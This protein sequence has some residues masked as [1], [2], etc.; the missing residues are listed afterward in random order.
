[1]KIK[2]TLL[3]L[4]CLLMV[5]SMAACSPSSDQSETPAS[6]AETA[7]N[8]GLSDGTYTASSKGH[9]GDVNVTV[10]ISNGKVE[11]VQIGEH[12]ETEGIYETP[13]ER[14]PKAIVEHQ[15]IAIDAVSG[16]TYT[17][18]AILDAVSQCIQQAGGKIEDFSTPVEKSSNAVEEYEADVVVI[19]AGGSGSASAVAAHQKGAKVIVIEKSANVGGSAALSGGMAAVNSSLQIADPETTFTPSEWLADWL[20]QQNYMVSAP[21]IYKF[22]SESGRT[23]DWLLENGMEMDFVAH[24][25]EALVDSPFRTYHAWAGEGFAASMAK[26][27]SKLSENN[28]QLMTETTATQLIM[29]DGKIA[30]VRA[31]K[32]DG[33]LVIIKSPAVILATGGYGASEEQ[34]M[35]VLGFKTNGIN[36]GTQTGD[37]IS[38]AIAVGAATEG[39]SN[40]EFHGAHSA[41]DL[42][43]DLPN[44]G[45]SLNHMAI[46]AAGL[47]VNVDGYRFTN[48]D[49]CYDSSYIGNVVAK[50]G[51]HY[52]VLVDQNFIDTLSDTG[53][54]GLGITK[55]GASFGV[56]GA[57]HDVAW[58]TLKEEIEAGLENGVTVKADTLEDLAIQAGINVNNLI[59]T[60]KTY[61]E[62]CRAGT[63]HMFSKEEQF[64]VPVVDG[65]YYLI[66]GRTT[67]LCSLG[68]VKITTDMEVVDTNN[69][70]IPGLY[71]AGV[72][73]SGSMYNNAYVSYEGV[74]MGWVMTSGRLAGENAGEYVKQ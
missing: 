24:H 67:Q 8:T 27:L 22:I 4:L 39:Y 48:E 54:T 11:Q 7:K 40:V 3:I 30:G 34:I 6:K 52:Y 13:V 10:L 45:S 42:I 72:D 60:V 46:N 21:M 9:N 56:D 20:K 28:G 16:A 47:W 14:I 58:T 71:S 49:I 57:R 50:Q 44:G 62:Y 37:G 66:M 23:V 59:D 17:S 51:D 41:F 12:N 26:M 68:G 19:G 64:M 32:S 31:E 2:K 43:E 35:E 69:Q 5:V 38:M 65:P 18:K 61:N 73:C 29:E 55:D 70:V 33:T 36:T 53:A 63:D 74:T 25:Q 15:S 1:M